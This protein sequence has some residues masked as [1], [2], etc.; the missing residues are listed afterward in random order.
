MPGK[1]GDKRQKWTR[2]WY[3]ICVGFVTSHKI[4][5]AKASQA[6]SPQGKATQSQTGPGSPRTEFSF[7]KLRQEIFFSPAGFKSREKGQ[8]DRVEHE[9]LA[10]Q[11]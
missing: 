11:R 7:K 1:D 6:V 4:G 2:D 5:D 3:R 10:T 8:K 9:E